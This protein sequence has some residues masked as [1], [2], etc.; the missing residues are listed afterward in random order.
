M[1]DGRKDARDDHPTPPDAQRG[2]P[3]D[4]KDHFLQREESERERRKDGHK[5]AAAWAAGRKQRAIDARKDIA[6]TWGSLT[7]NPEA[8]VELALHA[9]RMSRLNRVIDLADDRKEPTVSARAKVLVEREIARSSRVMLA[10]KAK[11]GAR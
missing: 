1:P 11:V 4:P 3:G 7:N 10:L 2:Q 8:R 5:D 6:A 9:D